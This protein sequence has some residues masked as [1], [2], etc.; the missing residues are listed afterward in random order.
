MKRLFAY[1]VIA[2]LS[3]CA[4]CVAAA[5]LG[6]ASALA[7][8]FVAQFPV[9]DP[10]DATD[11]GQG[12]LMLAVGFCVF[13]AF[14]IPL[15]IVGF[16]YLWKKCEANSFISSDTARRTRDTEQVGPEVTQSATQRPRPRAGQR[17][18]AP[19]DA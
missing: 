3:G 14:L 10:P 5:L 17:T 1:A 13:A 6:L 12:M 16:K 2:F 15:W 19:P 8:P 9:S 11:Y 18:P 4:A 7:T